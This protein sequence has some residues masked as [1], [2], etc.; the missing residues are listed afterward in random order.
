[1]KNLVSAAREWARDPAISLRNGLTMGVWL[2]V[3]A[4]MSMF[5]L[6]FLSAFLRVSV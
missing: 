6:G 1:M 4:A 3:V 2:Y 5:L